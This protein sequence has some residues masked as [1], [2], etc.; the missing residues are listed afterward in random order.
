MAT[1]LK[2][3]VMVGLV[4]QLLISCKPRVI[5]KI[6]DGKPVPV[7]IQYNKP[8]KLGDTVWIRCNFNVSYLI[9][10][11][12][13]LPKNNF[14]KYTAT[15]SSSFAYKLS[16]NQLINQ[17]I[18]EYI[19]VTENFPNFQLMYYNKI[20]QSFET[21][22]GF[23][24]NK[25]GSYSFQMSAILLQPDNNTTDNWALGTYFVGENPTKN[26]MRR[27]FEVQ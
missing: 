20:S 9:S 16:H 14:N 19:K 2:L 17:N 5:K 27:D 26:I 25:K 15:M 24:P 22:V 6:T 4:L 3:I 18:G 12:D 13:V 10:K 8:F 11:D 7:T 21:K 23:V 1:N